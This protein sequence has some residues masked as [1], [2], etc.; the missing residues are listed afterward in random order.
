MQLDFFGMWL[1]DLSTLQFGT[2]DKVGTNS[3]FFS[4][5]KTL[6]IDEEFFCHGGTG[7]F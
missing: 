5:S 7:Y 3:F 2:Y 4:F 6:T 1:I